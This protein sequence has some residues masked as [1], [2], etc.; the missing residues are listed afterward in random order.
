VREQASGRPKLKYPR[1]GLLVSATL[2][3]AAIVESKKRP[4][5]LLLHR[6]L[7]G[8]FRFRP[9]TGQASPQAFRA[10]SLRRW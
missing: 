6:E 4:C 9:A 5:P 8:V 1:P 7:L 3:V 2:K 10:P